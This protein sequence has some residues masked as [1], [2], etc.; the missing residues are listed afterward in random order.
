MKKSIQ[1]SILLLWSFTLVLNA[2]SV[3]DIGNFQNNTN[4]FDNGA[5][6]VAPINFLYKYSATQQ[7]YT[8]AELL[9]VANSEITKIKFKCKPDDWYSYEYDCAVKIYFVETAQSQYVKN[10]EDKYEWISVSNNDLVYSGNLTLDFQTPTTY[11]QDMVLEFDLT[12]AFSYQNQNLM[13][14]VVQEAPECLDISSSASFYAYPQNVSGLPYRT[15]YYCNDNTTLS[16]PYPTVSASALRELPSAEFTYIPDT[17]TNVPENTNTDIKVVLNKT[18][19]E[20]Q[21]AKGYATSVYDL[22]GKLL[23]SQLIDSERELLHINT[24]GM[25]IITLNSQNDVIVKKVFVD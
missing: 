18:N 15:L 7:I 12:T 6:P 14:M 19:V 1:I 13:V 2:Q 23:I 25:Y 9:S 5:D 11:E 17:E 3:C 8:S 22:S 4:L 20:I 16:D 10:T 24:S 21:N